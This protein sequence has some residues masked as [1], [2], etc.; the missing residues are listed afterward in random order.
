[1]GNS[2]GDLFCYKDKVK[3]IF[4]KN[5]FVN[6]LREVNLNLFLEYLINIID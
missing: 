3:I 1:M 2:V 4:F 5:Y 6:S